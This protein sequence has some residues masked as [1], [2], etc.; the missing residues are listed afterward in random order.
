MRSDLGKSFP[1]YKI[2]ENYMPE[3]SL[4]DMKNR[5]QFCFWENVISQQRR[6][7]KCDVFGNSDLDNPKYSRC[8]WIQGE[9]S[10]TEKVSYPKLK[11]WHGQFYFYS[12]NF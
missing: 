2:Q 6:Y 10:T 11:V 7:A 4:N 3:T 5:V 9:H 8:L 12:L 1:V